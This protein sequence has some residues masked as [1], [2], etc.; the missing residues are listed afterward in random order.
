MKYSILG[1]SQEKVLKLRRTDGSREQRID[2]C[3]LLI[4]REIA[5]F[6]NRRKVIKYCVEDK[7]YFHMKYTVILDDLPML[8][9]K[10]QALVD[11]IDKLCSFGLLEKLIIKNQ[12]G[13]FPA[14]CMGDA[15][16]DLLYSDYENCTC[17]QIQSDMYSDT[18]A[19]VVDYKCNIYSST[20]N[21]STSIKEEANASKK[22]EVITDDEEQRKAVSFKVK[23]KEY[24]NDKMRNKAIKPVRAIDNQRLLWLQARRREYGDDA[25]FEAIDNASKSSFLNGNNNRG[26][27]AT[28]DWIFRPN[29]FPKVLEG[30]YSDRDNAGQKPVS[31][32]KEDISWQ[33]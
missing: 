33:S 21:S 29:N 20:N 16:E 26:F 14:F 3:D 23:V 17:S 15:Y 6:M 11:R 10:Q 27:T 18:S 22:E 2:I 4:L 1:F 12:G 8:D 7:T 9:I 24:F 5:D 25:I 30:N 31:V 32:S 28:F 19:N 13:S